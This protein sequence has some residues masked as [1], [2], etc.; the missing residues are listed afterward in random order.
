MRGEGGLRP[1]EG[2]VSKFAQAAKAFMDSSSA[3]RVNLDKLAKTRHPADLG[4]GGGDA[5][6]TMIL[7]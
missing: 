3:R 6:R 4:N 1:G 2:C 7:I 5:R